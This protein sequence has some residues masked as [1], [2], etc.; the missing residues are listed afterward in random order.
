VR[1]SYPVCQEPVPYFYEEGEGGEGAG[2]ESV[3]ELGMIQRIFGM[4]GGWGGRNLCVVG[5]P[6]VSIGTAAVQSTCCEEE[7]DTY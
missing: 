2:E 1:F 3:V 5:M 7:H 6:S 4:G